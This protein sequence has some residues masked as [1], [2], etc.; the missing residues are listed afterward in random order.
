M[1]DFIGFICLVEIV[2]FLNI[3]LLGMVIIG[4]CVV[5]LADI[6]KVIHRLCEFWSAAKAFS[7]INQTFSL[8]ARRFYSNI[9]FRQG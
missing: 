1:V 4:F 6:H 7:F 3:L 2:N 9:A 5:R 8:G